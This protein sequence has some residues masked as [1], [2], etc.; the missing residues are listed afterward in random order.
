M[1]T[2]LRNQ[3]RQTPLPKWRPL[4]PLFEA[5]MNSFH[6][7]RDAKRTDNA[8]ILIE[9]E[10]DTIL[11]KEESP[12]I[13][14]FKITDNGV[15]FND[16]N[17]DSF[18]T[19]FSELRLSQGGK[20]LGRFTWL[21]AF[22]RVEIDSVYSEPGLQ[23][24][25]QRKFIFDESYDADKATP[26]RAE[27]G[28]SAVTTVRLAGF[29]EPYRSQCP[30]TADQIIQRLV[31]HFLLIF[32]EPN[33]PI[34]RVHDQGLNFLANDVFEKDFKTTASTHSFDLKGSTFTI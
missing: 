11:F 5:V 6:A 12:P 30:K 10:R 7:I 19:A 31:E 17:F 2:N 21:K 22:D 4:I 27:T 32:L 13:T 26:R 15:G 28:L 25:L 20:G 9:I 34:V 24:P 1:L 14:A 23:E 29:K 33:C 18:N 3:V 8:T 16:L